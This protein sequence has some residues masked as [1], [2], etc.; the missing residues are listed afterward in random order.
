MN[1]AKDNF[2][3]E[4]I[5]QFYKVIEISEK[6]LKENQGGFKMDE[7]RVKKFK[8]NNQ[9]VLKKVKTPSD[10]IKHEDLNRFLFTCNRKS[11][12]ASFI[13]HVRNA[14][15]HSNISIDGDYFL[16]E[17]YKIAKKVGKVMTA[18]GR[19]RRDLL[20]PLI[21]CMMEDR[22]ENLNLKKNNEVHN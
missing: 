13:A 8:D 19:I 22:E 2:S 21:D 17:D 15:S 5:L 14:Y 6:E 10:I 9:I 3:T 1:I 4:E 11:Q 7:G 12:G 18:Y 16:I 20:F